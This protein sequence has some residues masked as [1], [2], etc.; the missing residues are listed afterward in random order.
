MDFTYYI[1]NLQLIDHREIVWQL[2][3]LNLSS[4]NL[5]ASYL[6]SM[7]PLLKKLQEI[8]KPC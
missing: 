8:K 7:K 3:N 5:A 4:T 1:I 2:E 6:V